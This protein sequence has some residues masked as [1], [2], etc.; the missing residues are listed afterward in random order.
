[1]SAPFLATLAAELSQLG[2]VSLLLELLLGNLLFFCLF[3][4]LTFEYSLLVGSIIFFL[5][6]SDDY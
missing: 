6:D 2:L 3:A 5:F 1:M 4:L